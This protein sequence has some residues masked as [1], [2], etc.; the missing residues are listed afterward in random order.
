MFRIDAVFCA[1]IQCL[2]SYVYDILCAFL[3]FIQLLTFVD[4]PFST[5]F[6]CNDSAW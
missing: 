1:R 2:A 4:E 5:H 3:T 6:K